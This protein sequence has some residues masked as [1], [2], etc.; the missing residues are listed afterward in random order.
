ME[1]RI[2][3]RPVVV[4]RRVIVERP[5]VVARPYPFFR[6]YPFYRPFYRPFFGRPF[7]PGR[8]AY[9]GGFGPY[10]YGRY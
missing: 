5:V 2:I 1:R 10:G 6:P 7:F 3:E 9:A 4:E 8:F